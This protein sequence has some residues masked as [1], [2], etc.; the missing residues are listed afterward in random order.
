MEIKEFFIGEISVKR[1]L[2]YNEAF[3][4]DVKHKRGFYRMAGSEFHRIIISAIHRI[5]C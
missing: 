5:A 4:I 2:L 3:H 1:H